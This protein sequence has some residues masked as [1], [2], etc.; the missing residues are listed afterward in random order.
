M[1]YLINMV[2]ISLFCA[3]LKQATEPGMLLCRLNDW[4]WHFA[5]ADP[6]WWYYPILGC[7]YCF[8]SLWGSAIYWLL[9]LFVWDYEV[10]ASTWI[11]WP[12]TCVA[13]V[14]LNGIMYNMLKKLEA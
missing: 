9:E 10:T 7:V 11:M 1:D 4:L 5:G 6:A 3:G 12:V 13:C 14:F 2:I 8:A